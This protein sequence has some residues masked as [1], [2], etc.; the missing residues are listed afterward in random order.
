M[1]QT[2][3]YI[4]FAIAGLVAFS[5]CKKELDLQPID[6]F[7]EANAFV[8][9]TDIKAGVNA[10]HS[11]Y[12][13]YF[14]DMY[15]SALT[16]DEAKIGPG[17]AGQGALEF[18]FQYA[19][20]ATSG[21]SVQ[22]AFGDYYALID[23]VNRVLPRIPLVSATAAEE[24]LRDIYKGQL[25]ALRAIAHFDLL[26]NYSK[27]YNASDPLGIAIMTVS[28]PLAQPTRNSMGDVM[29]QIEADLAAAKTLLPAVDASTFTD[30]EMNRLNVAAYQAR[31]ALYKGDYDQA[32]AYSTEV[33]SSGI[34]PLA[35]GPQFQ[36]IWTDDTQDELLFRVRLENS[37]AV[38]SAFT[39]SGG[40]I[41]ISPSDKLV[42]SYDA[43]DIRLAAYV[44]NNSNGRYV[45][46]FFESSRGGR[47]VDIKAIRTAEMYLI[48]AEANAKKS[49]PD[50][51]AATDDLN[52]LRSNRI[53]GYV[54]E[55]FPN[56]TV[57]ITAILDERFKELAFEGQ[58][59][60]D[61]KRNNLPVQR[62]ASDA[63]AAWQTL[64]AGN[65]RFVYPIPQAEIFANPNMAQNEGYN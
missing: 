23:Q 12:S 20:D 61:L 32:V 28:N 54:D 58:R 1:K 19:A 44:G 59:F 3:K 22:A 8:N 17:N 30:L 2:N 24:P 41:Y 34:K 60:Y 9:M 21:G 46:K 40:D 15:A 6:T 62:L 31:I 64:D 18:R 37:S 38:G 7:N 50:L 65:Y 10:A 51:G 55:T 48:R 29:A 25:L 39:T 36:A 53:P 16:S 33:I 52:E 56:A 11:R 27:N 26:K 14:D 43:T 13:A 49:S 4:A 45:N 42:A 35:S 5:S 57:L 47:I 63:S